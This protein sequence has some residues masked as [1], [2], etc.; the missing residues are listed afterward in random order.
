MIEDLQYLTGVFWHVFQNDVRDSGN[1]GD[2]LGADIAG[3]FAPGKRR[4][5]RQRIVHGFA[6]SAG[7][8]QP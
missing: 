5:C 3:L 2:P 1:H 7:P 6:A 8:H 4:K